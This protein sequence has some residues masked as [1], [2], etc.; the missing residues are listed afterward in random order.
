VGVR[1]MTPQHF[2]APSAIQAH[3]VIGPHRL[4]K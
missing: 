1:E 2:R 3:K 4:A